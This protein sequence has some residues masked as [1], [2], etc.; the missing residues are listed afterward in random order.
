MAIGTMTKGEKAVV[1]VNS[2]Y[3]TPCPLMPSIE[4]K[5]LQFEVDLVHFIQVFVI[6][7]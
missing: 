5:E 7:C 1:Y 4:D 3:L 2:P 6:F